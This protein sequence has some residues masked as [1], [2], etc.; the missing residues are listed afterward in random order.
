MCYRLVNANPCRC[1]ALLPSCNQNHI[2]PAKGMSSRVRSSHSYSA[3]HPREEPFCVACD[4]CFGGLPGLGVSVA[5]QRS[6][7]QSPSIPST[8]GQSSDASMDGPNCWCAIVPL[9]RWHVQRRPCAHGEMLCLYAPRRAAV[10]RAECRQQ[11]AFR[12]DHR[13]VMHMCA[14]TLLYDVWPHPCWMGCVQKVCAKVSG[15]VLF[16]SVGAGQGGGVSG[17]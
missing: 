5:Q 14:F 9:R 1:P 2:H 13:K 8:P 6:A 15:M 11:E 7:S 17:W 16:P 3:Y 12:G 10:H 4:D